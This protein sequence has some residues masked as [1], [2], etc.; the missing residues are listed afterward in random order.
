[1]FEVAISPVVRVADALP[2]AGRSA[3]CLAAA[4]AQAP[5]PAAISLLN[6][7]DPVAL[8]D[9]DRVVHLQAWERCAR[10]LAAKQ[11]AAVVAV[12]GAAPADRDDFAREH[13]RLALVGCGGSARADVDTARALAGPLAEA[14]AALTRG[15]LSYG[16]VRVLEQE[17]RLCDPA[18]AREVSAAVLRSALRSGSIRVAPSELR[19]RVRR[20]ITRVDPLWAELSAER[21]GAARQVTRRI[22][23]DAQ[24]SLCLTGPA[25]DVAAIRA[26]LDRRAA[27]ATT[28]DGVPDGRTL[29]QR[30][31]DAMVEICRNDGPA[32]RDVTTRA[33]AGSGAVV[34]VFADAPTW[35]G[36]VDGPVELAG[37]G[38]IPAGLAR[39][40]FADARWRAVVTEAL[41]GAVRA[42][43]D[44]GYTPGA[45]T[46]RH[47][48]VA[49]RG[50]L[51]PGCGASVAVCD[52]DHN[53]PFDQGGRTDTDNCGLLCRRHH[54]LKTFTRWSWRRCP[55]GTVEWTDPHG[56]RW[57]RDP[58]R[59]LLPPPD[60]PPLEPA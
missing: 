51:F 3:R 28:G 12:A 22:E 33:G 41:T 23:P 24:A 17:T 60:V 32:D 58:V 44:R 20:A 11:A 56:L 26:A 34:H 48:D 5:G 52:A 2:P 9:V 39:E 31:F 8:D 35:A 55:D 45:R 49:D 40:H 10:W 6:R 16:H 50:C 14:G 25:P 15:E 53:I 43:S 13:V 54:R 4:V 21:A 57:H 46:S 19:R 18:T 1:M 42:V 7:V 47:L 27:R 59:Y 30:R 36:L 37:Y 38:P 29:D